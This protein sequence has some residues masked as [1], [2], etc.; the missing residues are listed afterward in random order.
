MKPHCDH[1]YLYQSVLFCTITQMLLLYRDP[2]G[3]TFETTATE[4]YQRNGSIVLANKQESSAELLGKVA[5]LEKKVAE[6]EL[7][8][9]KMK[10]EIQQLHE[11]R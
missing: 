3:R 4:A 11:V 7:T 10:R 2:T 6:N 8:M 5:L 1:A 9:D